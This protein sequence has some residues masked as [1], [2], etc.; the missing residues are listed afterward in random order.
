MLVDVIPPYGTDLELNEGF[1]GSLES[2]YNDAG[3]GISGVPGR[4]AARVALKE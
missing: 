2:V 3:S 4:N 1:T